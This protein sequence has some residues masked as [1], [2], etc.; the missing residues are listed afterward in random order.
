MSRYFFH[1]QVSGQRTEDLRGK[2]YKTDEA[3]CHRAEQQMPGHLKKA[4]MRSRNTYVA[5]EVTDGKRTLFVVR[6]TVIVDRR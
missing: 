2:L 4:A 5:T 6:G 1:Q 3:A